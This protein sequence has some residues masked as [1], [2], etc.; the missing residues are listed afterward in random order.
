MPRRRGRRCPT[1]T[2]PSFPP[3]RSRASIRRSG[4]GS[5]SA[6]A[7]R[8][9]RRRAAGRRSGP[10]EHVL[11]A[12]PTGAGKTLA[13]F[14][15]AIDGLLRQGAALRDETQVLYV[16]PLKALGND[17]QKN[18]AAPLARDP[19]G[20]TRRC[21]TCACSCGPATRRRRSAPR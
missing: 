9:R 20:A 21:P 2:V 4:A 12:A 1:P 17:V 19:R 7:S 14:L 13:A 11:I 10:G 15:I 16:S 5:R 6:S 18:L 8:R 3:C